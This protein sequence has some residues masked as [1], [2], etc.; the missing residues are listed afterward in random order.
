MKYNKGFFGFS[1][2]FLS[3]S[4]CYS[5]A[6]FALVQA[7]E[8]SM[9]YESIRFGKQLGLMTICSFRKNRGTNVVCM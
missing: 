4:V 6:L 5:S 7:P 1:E 8:W 2:Q 9:K 3:F